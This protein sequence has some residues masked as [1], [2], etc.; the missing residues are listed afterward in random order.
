MK[1]A[2]PILKCIAL[3]TLSLVVTTTAWAATT[4]TIVTVN[5]PAKGP[6]VVPTTVPGAAVG[7]PGFFAYPA[8][9]VVGPRVPPATP[10]T[11]TPGRILVTG[12]MSPVVTIV[13]SSAGTVQKIIINTDSRDAATLLYQVR[14]SAG[15]EGRTRPLDVRTW[16]VARA[17]LAVA[18]VGSGTV[19]QAS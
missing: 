7:K 6:L 1:T 10:A 19:W 2:A 14:T 16:K 8:K 11:A 5:P 12:T 13:S 15:P 4:A 18:R 17:A 9:R 3:A